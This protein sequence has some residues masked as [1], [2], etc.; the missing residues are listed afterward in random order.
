MARKSRKNIEPVTS[1]VYETPTYNAAA[2]IR[3]SADARRKPGDSLESQRNIIENFIA[4]T[5]DI[6]L[7]D[8]YCDNNRTGTS[9][10]RPEFQKMLADIDARRIDCIIVKDLSRFGRNAIDTGFYVE[11][12]L[13]SLNVRF[14]AVTDGFDSL[15]GDGGIMLPLKNIISEAYAADISR[16]CKSVQ[17]QHISEGRFAGRVAPYGYELSPTD[18]HKL[19]IDCEA[20]VTVREIFDWAAQNVSL[21]EIARRLNDKQILPPSRYMQSKKGLTA[22]GKAVGDGFWKS[23]SVK[24]ILTNRIYT[25]DM[26]QGKP[27]T[28]N[29][30]EISVPPDEW[31]H[32]PSTH[33]PIIGRELFERVQALLAQRSAQDNA[34]H[35]KPVAHSENIFKGKV[36]CAKCGRLLHRYRQSRNGSYDFRCNTKWDIAKDA[37]VV[38]SVKEAELKTEILALLHKHSEAIF[39]HYIGVKRERTSASADADLREINAKLDKSGRMLKSL[40]ESMMSGLITSDEFV[41]MKAGYEA[42]IAELSER[43]NELRDVKRKTED[44]VT[45]YRNLADAVSA[46]LADERLTKELIDRLVDKILVKPDKSFEIRFKFADVFGGAASEV[47]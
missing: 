36:F 5:P 22:D 44:N 2:Y 7:A 30:A 8:V 41:E 42:K 17:R 3:L 11:K 34:A 12:Y 9:F 45:E 4:S 46:V 32:V 47:A 27:R 35:C 25:G 15:Y 24:R 33:E 14:I 26:A 43:A 37:C 40:Y 1:A 10:E 39:G 31:V 18:C 6:R 21:G 20:A 38:V 16:K 13:P 19:V 29:Y 23:I 28:E